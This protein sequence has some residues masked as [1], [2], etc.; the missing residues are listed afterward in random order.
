[1]VAAVEIPVCEAGNPPS[2]PPNADTPRD[3]AGVVEKAEP[4][5]PKP[6]W[7]AD[8]VAT[9]KPRDVAVDAA[10]APKAPNAVDVEVGAAAPNPK[11]GVEVAGA[12]KAPVEVGAPKVR[13]PDAINI[14]NL[15]YA[16]F[17]GTL[18]SAILTF[19]RHLKSECLINLNH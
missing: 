12:P 17:V 3:V 6:G 9:P 8:V 5:S 2:P 16:S 4:P 13:L 14:I 10:G 1:M 11:A 15:N 18:F 19:N 7:L